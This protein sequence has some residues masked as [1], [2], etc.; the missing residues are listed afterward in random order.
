[1]DPEMKSNI[2]R[3]SALADPNYAYSVHAEIAGLNPGRPYWYRFM[4][5][6]AVSPV[7]R[8]MTAPAPGSAPARLNFGFVSCAN[9]EH[10]YFSAFG[11]LP[12]EEPARVLFRADF[13]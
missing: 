3:G 5:G 12:R 2:R 9:Y 7:G 4:S 8:A 13:I 11:H 10:G 6:D 1:T